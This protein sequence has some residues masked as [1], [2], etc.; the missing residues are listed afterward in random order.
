MTP[1]TTS[2]PHIASIEE[3]LVGA[4]WAIAHGDAGGLS[5]V[6]TELSSKVGAALRTDLLDL[7]ALCHVAYET[8]AERWP[9]LR[10]RARAAA[11]LS[12]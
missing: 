5:W 4:D 7:A 10:D 11:M 2:S 3:L 6:L 8:A 9:A 1:L 12:N